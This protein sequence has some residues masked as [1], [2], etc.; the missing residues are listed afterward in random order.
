MK[1]TV[2][3]MDGEID[4]QFFKTNRMSGPSYILYNFSNVRQKIRWL[5]SKI[6]GFS[7]SSS[8]SIIYRADAN[9]HGWMWNDFHSKC[10]GAAPTLVIVQCSSGSICGGFTKVAWDGDS[11]NYFSDGSAFLFSIDK[12]TTYTPKNKEY[13]VYNKKNNGPSFGGGALDFRNEPMNG[14]KKGMSLFNRD[15]VH[16][17]IPKVDGKN[18]LTGEEDEYFTCKKLEVYRVNL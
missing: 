13:A 9:G 3:F 16:Y 15:D 7:L 14:E 1:I 8:L 18:P 4:S 6:P 5:F 2:D 11:G 10:N 17:N 12:E